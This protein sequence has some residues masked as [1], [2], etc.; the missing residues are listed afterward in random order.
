MLGGDGKIIAKGS[1]EGGVLSSVKFDFGCEPDAAQ[2]GEGS[3]SNQALPP[4]RGVREQRRGRGDRSLVYSRQNPPA[5]KVVNGVA[6]DR[7]TP[8]VNHFRLAHSPHTAKMQ[9]SPRLWG[10]SCAPSL[11]APENLDSGSL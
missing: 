4:T 7:T 6:G 3:S 5:P 2:P 10:Q 8:C 9:P 1:D 11:R